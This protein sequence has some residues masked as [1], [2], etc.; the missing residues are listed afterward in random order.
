[1]RATGRLSLPLL[2]QRVG[3]DDHGRA[4]P[5]DDAA[6]LTHGLDGGTNF[7]GELPV[8]VGDPTAAEVVRA[9]LDLDLVAREDPDVVLP[10]LPGDGREDGVATPVELHPEHRA[11]ER[12]D[13]LA[14]NLDLLFLGRQ[15]PFSE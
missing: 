1:M 8:P 15:I 7:H 13:D 11:R 3:A 6:A 14:F 5:L 10:H 9:E 12:F 4:V 2:V